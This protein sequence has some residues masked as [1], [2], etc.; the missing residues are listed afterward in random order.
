MLDTEDIP[1]LG[2]AFLYRSRLVPIGLQQKRSGDGYE[3]KG[4]FV[5]ETGV[6][7]VTEAGPEGMAALLN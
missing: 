3:S 5:T 4:R 2:R 6:I 1:F 7:A